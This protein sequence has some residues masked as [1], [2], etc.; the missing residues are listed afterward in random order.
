VKQSSLRRRGTDPEQAEQARPRIVSRETKR[1]R[2]RLD[3]R[4]AATCW[5]FQLLVQII[6]SVVR[7]S[8]VQAEHVLVTVVA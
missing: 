6:V 8:T 5:K 2:F 4:T 1:P 7:S 3:A